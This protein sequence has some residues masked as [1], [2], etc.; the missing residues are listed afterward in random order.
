M[1]QFGAKVVFAQEFPLIKFCHFFRNAKK[2]AVETG[3]HRSRCVL[4]ESVDVDLLGVG[5]QD[6]LDQSVEIIVDAASTRALDH[7]RAK[8]KLKALVPQDAKEA[9]ATGCGP[10]DQSLARS[11][12][13]FWNWRPVMQRSS[14]GTGDGG[15]WVRFAKNGGFS[16]LLL[17][18]LSKAHTWTATVLVDEL[19]ARGA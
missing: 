18:R 16:P 19:D 6:H 8:T 4:G 17:W 14:D 5:F 15:D 3:K 12:L 11:A 9:Q 13:R 7:D 2:P 10:S 1:H